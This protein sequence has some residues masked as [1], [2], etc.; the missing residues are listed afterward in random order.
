MA[1]RP[2]LA[3]LLRD[4]PRH[5][6]VQFV[7]AL[8]A[9]RGAATRIEG[10]VV[11]VDG[12]R[13]LVAARW[14]SLTALVGRRGERADRV[15]AVDPARAG[16]LGDRYGARAVS[17][18]DLDRLARYGLDRPAADAVYRKQFGRPVAEVDPPAAD[19]RPG[20][21]D[22]TDT[23]DTPTG[24]HASTVGLV[25]VSVLAIL[26]VT[27]LSGVGATTGALPWVW[28]ASETVSV[29]T[30]AGT[31]TGTHDDGTTTDA[32]T[33]SPAA[34]SV[35]GAGDPSTADPF[36]PGVSN[37]RLTDVDALATAHAAALGNRSYV[38]ELEYVE[39]VNG[40]VTAR[41]TETVRV[42]SRRSF[43][44]AVDWRGR[45]AGLTPVASRPSYADGEVRH[46]PAADGSELVT[47]ALTD[48]S[49]AGEQG[50]RASRYLRWYLSTTN[51]S[52]E[53]T[54]V[55]AETPTAVIEGTGTAYP[56]A[57]AYTVRAH[58]TRGGFVRSLSVSYRLTDD[59]GPPVAVQFSFR[60]RVGEPVVVSPP[61]WH[62]DGATSTPNETANQTSTPNETA[63]Q[64]STPSTG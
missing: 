18:V 40:T 64:T 62:D 52:V 46:R 54:L 1:S 10:N 25:V 63:N 47:Y 23:A 32:T 56:N 45:P 17:A 36:A 19:R 28:G 20:R 12:E 8:Y 59:G 11:H 9:A 7:A 24:G 6:R 4:Q 29:S 3:A 14:S 42:A 22:A 49:P 48:L 44:S 5:D 31:G 16:T 60:Y 34:H 13:Y 27:A 30:P 33:A 26:L 39:S 15:V 2:T 51:A 57:E 21:A 41:G 58:V 35:R 43:V 61:A 38:W 50:W 55:H 37:A 53:R